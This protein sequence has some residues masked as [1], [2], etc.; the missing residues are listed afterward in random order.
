MGFLF[1]SESFPGLQSSH[2][3]NLS[4]QIL[5]HLP[6]TST[7]RFPLVNSLKASVTCSF[8]RVFLK[9]RFTVPS[10]FWKG[11]QRCERD[12]ERGSQGKG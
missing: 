2:Q 7:L 9:S 6:L 11:R 1:L 12:R 3:R 8:V 5:Q 10:S 4:L